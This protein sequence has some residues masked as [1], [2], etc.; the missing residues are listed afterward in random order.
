MNNK[1]LKARQQGHHDGKLYS[2]QIV[3]IV[4]ERGNKIKH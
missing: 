3:M 4:K 1:T 2:T